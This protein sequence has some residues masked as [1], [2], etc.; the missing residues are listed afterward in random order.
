MLKPSARKLEAKRVKQVGRGS[1][2]F[3]PGKS[4]QSPHKSHKPMPARR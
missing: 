3:K 2:Q 4:G 1:G